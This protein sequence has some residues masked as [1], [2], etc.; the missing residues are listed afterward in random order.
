VPAFS[1][2]NHSFKIV[3]ET[4]LYWPLENALIVADLHL[5]KA[6]WFAS[7][8]QMLPPYDSLATLDRLAKLIEQTG[9]EQLWCL[10]DNFHDEA[11]PDRMASPARAKLASMTAAI[12]WH[13]ITGNHDQRLPAGIGGTVHDE[14]E[15]GGLI[16]RHHANTPDMRPELSG[17]WHPKHRATARGRGVTRPCFVMGTSRLILPA[18]GALT[19]GMAADHPEIMALTGKA[20]AIL[21]AGGRAARFPL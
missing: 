9:A 5:E 14:A 8:G 18:F 4:G 3:G 7:K 16:L 13:W 17:H 11:G 19:G 2:A 21:V 1:F 10:G 6:S 15:L 20:E 12:R